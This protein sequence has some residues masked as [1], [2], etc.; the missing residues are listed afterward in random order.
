[1]SRESLLEKLR[2]PDY[3]RANPQSM[4]TYAGPSVDFDA[5]S[6]SGFAEFVPITIRAK[7]VRNTN[8]DIERD[9]SRI[10]AK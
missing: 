2:N 10:R 1:M 8:A 7:T 6:V 3:E 9:K 4:V 5:A